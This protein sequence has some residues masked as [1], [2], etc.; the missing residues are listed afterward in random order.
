MLVVEPHADRD[1]ILREAGNYIIHRHFAT[2][3]FQ[4]RIQEEGREFCKQ[5]NMT[6]LFFKLSIMM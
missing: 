6:D 1:N 3:K 4:S 5:K 2:H